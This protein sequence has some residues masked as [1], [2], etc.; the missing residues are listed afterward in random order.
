MKWI[1][2]VGIFLAKFPIPGKQWNLWFWYQAS[3]IMIGIISLLAW[4]VWSVF[5]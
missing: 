5:V 3:I 1:P 4:A 2:V